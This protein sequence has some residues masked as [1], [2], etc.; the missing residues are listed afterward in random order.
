M[1]DRG[2]TA[3]VQLSF[4]GK[5]FESVSNQALHQFYLTRIMARQGLGMTSKGQGRSQT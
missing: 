5:E 2:N 4:R 3:H 1:G